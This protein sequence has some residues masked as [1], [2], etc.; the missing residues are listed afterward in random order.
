MQNFFKAHDVYDPLGRRIDKRE[1]DH[2]GGKTVIE[3]YVYR[4][5][6]IVFR[7]IVDL[8]TGVRAVNQVF[9]ANVLC[10]TRS[11]SRTIRT[12]CALPVAGIKSGARA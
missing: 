1:T 2:T 8:C 3:Q 5:E 11:L 10:K 6:D 12:Q 9:M 4:N 7:I